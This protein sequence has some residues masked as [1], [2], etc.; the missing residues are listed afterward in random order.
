[1][2]ADA[3]CEQLIQEDACDLSSAGGRAEFRCLESVPIAKD[4][5]R[6]LPALSRQPIRSQTLTAE[7]Y[8]YRSCNSSMR[9]GPRRNGTTRWK[10]GSHRGGGLSDS[11]VGHSQATAYAPRS[12]RSGEG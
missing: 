3:G 1:M 7:P 11:R 12:V 10:E 4:A 8:L 5:G 9:H 2:S 6:Y